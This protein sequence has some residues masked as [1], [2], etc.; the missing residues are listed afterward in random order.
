MP[1][2]KVMVPTDKRPRLP[3]KGAPGGRPSW[4]FGH[5][6]HNGPWAWNWDGFHDHFDK[7]MAMEA[8]N[9]TE[10]THSGSVGAKRI[11]LDNLGGDAQTRLFRLDFDDADALWELRVGGKPRLWGVRSE[12]CFHFLW[13]DPEHTVSPSRRR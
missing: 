13:W 11:R 1:R 2:Q 3:V 12:N 6:D 5:C 4:R 8:K 10:F 9:W 7:L